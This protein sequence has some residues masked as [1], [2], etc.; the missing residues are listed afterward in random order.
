MKVEIVAIGSEILS[1]FTINTNAA[2]ISQELLKQGINTHY[3]TIVSDDGNAL[4]KALKEALERSDIVITT[5]GLGPTCD[6]LT[7]S[8]AADLFDSEFVHYPEI[9]EDLEKRYGKK[10]VSARDQ[11][12]LPVKAEI[13]KNSLGT[14]SGLLFSKKKKSLFL[15]P[16]V[17]PEMREMFS[18]SVLPKIVSKLPLENRKVSIW[19]YFMFLFESQVDPVL[20]RLH[21]QYPQ[22][23]MGIYPDRGLITVHL[24]GFDEE[25]SALE[26]C[27]KELL[28]EFGNYQYKS[29]SG[30]I[31]E[32]VHILFST[33]GL[34]LV[35]AESCTG[36]AIASRLTALSGASQY[37]L[38]G[39]ITYSN[40]M[41]TNLLGVSEQSLEDHGA[42]SEEVVMQMAEGAINR[43]GAEYGIAVT[44]IA[45]P[46][47][48]TKEKPVGTVWAAIAGKNIDTISWLIQG[49]KASREMV[50]NYTVNTV[51]GRLYH[52]VSR[53]IS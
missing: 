36:G 46:N 53:S 47:G 9:E 42:V 41:K 27:Q 37:F 17:P 24:A 34:T 25:R 12:T 50:V 4:R 39:M 29:P 38:G 40:Q 5:G 21:E 7:R 15:L 18:Q 1:G 33:Q 10:L 19:L 35:T 31:E 43:T 11:A 32:A 6:D 26:I 13:I 3:H 44:G 52:T 49:R 14:A 2:F 48:G 23:E 51:L 45:G 16:G 30:S 8:V 22:I 20:R 28:K